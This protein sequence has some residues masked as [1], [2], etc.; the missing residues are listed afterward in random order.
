MSELEP[1]RL[2]RRGFF[3][4]GLAM[5][6]GMGSL[7]AFLAA[8]LRMP[9][10]SLLPGRSRQFRIGER[11]DFPPGTTRYFEDQQTF[12]FADQEGIFAMSATCTHL[13]CIVRR[14]Q[15]QFT[16]P[17]HGSRYDLTGRVLQG[18][19]P[20]SLSWYAV[21]RLPGGRLVV[22]RALVVPPGTK[23]LV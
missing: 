10:P 2:T 15:Q 17:C 4:W 6:S 5:F 14:E 19:A 12:V 16:C 21:Q 7:I 13:G 18:P 22:D 1:T 3:G 11:E 8:T 23:L 9:L 20:K